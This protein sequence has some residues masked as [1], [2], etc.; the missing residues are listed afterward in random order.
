M[1]TMDTVKKMGGR[2]SVFHD[3]GGKVNR[4]GIKNAI[5][6]SLD[7]KVI[8]FFLFYREMCQKFKFFR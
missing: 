8:S 3:I 1:A 7:S 5:Q 4:E 6:K 2:V